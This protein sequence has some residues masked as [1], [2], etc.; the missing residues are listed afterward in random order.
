MP[1]WETAVAGGS[2]SV[3]VAWRER[4]LVRKRG[5]AASVLALVWMVVGL[6]TAQERGRVVFDEA[7]T[8][9]VVSEIVEK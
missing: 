1:K 5:F 9:P 7:A 2:V 3:F 8:Q 6:G 4:A